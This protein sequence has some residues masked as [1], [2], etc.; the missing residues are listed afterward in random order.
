MSLQIKGVVEAFSTEGA[1]VPLGVRVA[2]HVP[3]EESLEGE[4]L[5]AGPTLEFGRIGGCP[6]GRELLLALGANL[7]GHRVLDSVSAIDQLNGA[8]TGDSNL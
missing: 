1:K 4:G 8:V 3:V 5:G 2:L 7:R 6:H